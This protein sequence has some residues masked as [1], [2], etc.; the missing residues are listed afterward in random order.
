MIIKH[1]GNTSILITSICD[2][3]QPFWISSQVAL[4]WNFWSIDSLY[5]GYMWLW[6]LYDKALILCHV[7][8]SA[9]HIVFF[10]LSASG[11]LKLEN[12]NIQPSRG[13]SKQKMK[14]CFISWICQESGPFTEYNDITYITRFKDSQF[15]CVHR[16]KMIGSLR[17]CLS[18]ET[19]LL[20]ALAQWH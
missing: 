6:T 14:T 5:I 13:T 20:I 4:F 19:V 8:D 3:S 10:L 16:T 2:H 11:V 18:F 9:H 17:Q 7:I 12:N 1:D 15:H